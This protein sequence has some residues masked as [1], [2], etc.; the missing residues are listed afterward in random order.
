[1]VIRGRT[2]Q[3][4]LGAAMLV[5]SPW[6]DG[7]E[8]SSLEQGWQLKVATPE[9][10]TVAQ[11]QT[12]GQFKYFG[13]TQDGLFISLH[14][15]SI[16][17]AVQSHQ[18]CIDHYWPNRSPSS[19]QVDLASINFSE[20]PTFEAVTYNY[21]ISHAQRTWDIPNAHFYFAINGQCADLH[22]GASP[23]YPKFHQL[24]QILADSLQVSAKPLVAQVGSADR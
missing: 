21:R 19:L 15:A 23:R 1:M 20:R 12:N 18:E 6:V 16:P 24:I 9:L 2:S 10:Q 14:V 17:V 7:L 8:L 4:L 3:K 22:V 5:L 11:S 13:K